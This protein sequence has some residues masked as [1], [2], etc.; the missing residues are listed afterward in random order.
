M[1]FDGK[2]SKVLPGKQIAF[3]D[4]P[5]E[6]LPVGSRVVGRFSEC[7]K[8]I[9]IEKPKCQL[10]SEREKIIFSKYYNSVRDINFK[11]LVGNLIIF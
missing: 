4:S 1:K 5:K 9:F 10:S 7:S 3:A 8:K 6:T 2:G 11:N